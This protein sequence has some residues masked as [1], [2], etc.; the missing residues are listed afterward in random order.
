MHSSPISRSRLSYPTTHDNGWARTSTWTVLPEPVW[1]AVEAGGDGNWTISDSSSPRWALFVRDQSRATLLH[2]DAMPDR[3]NITLLN[4]KTGKDQK[5]LPTNI[6]PNGPLTMQFIQGPKSEGRF[7]GLDAVMA[8][9]LPITKP[10]DGNTN[11]IMLPNT[12]LGQNSNGQPVLIRNRHFENN[13]DI[14]ISQ[15][16]GWQIEIPFFPPNAMGFFVSGTRT[17]P[18]YYT[19]TAGGQLFRWNG[20]NWGNAILT[21]LVFDVATNG[22][23]GSV[24]VNP[25]D[26]QVVYAIT[27][28]AIMR[29]INGGSNFAAE[30]AL[31]LLVT[32]SGKLP[33]TSLSHMAFHYE[34][35][36]EVVAGASNG[37]FYSAGGGKWTDLRNF[38]PKPMV[39]PASGRYRFRIRIRCGERA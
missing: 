6:G 24:F 2:F 19:F 18:I 25:Y 12:P 10:W 39:Q 17:A 13:P 5:P 4:I 32:A 34:N 8:V 7:P 31:T 33:T 38:V 36:E 15:A 30:N 9:D 37:V 27:A 23:Y 20:A 29:S 21:G 35:P 26:Q 11:P 22:T 16:A 1:D 28:N 14:N 3:Q